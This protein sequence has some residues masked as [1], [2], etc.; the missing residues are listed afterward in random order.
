M[1][2]NELSQ[3]LKAAQKCLAARGR[4]RCKGCPD[5]GMAGVCVKNRLTPLPA[6]QPKRQRS[7]N[8]GECCDG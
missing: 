2:D 8:G 4:L 7:D 3:R 5:S 6:A 1:T